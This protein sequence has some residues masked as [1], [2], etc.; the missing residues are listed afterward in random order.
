M[1]LYYERKANSRR[2]K[3][4]IKGAEVLCFSKV[5]S[6]ALTGGEFEV[7]RRLKTFLMS[8]PESK[9]SLSRN[10]AQVQCSSLI[11]SFTQKDGEDGKRGLKADKI[12]SK[13]F[14]ECLFVRVLFNIKP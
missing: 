4:L 12:C 7:R 3:N 5:I 1:L 11:F 6:L 2:N 9:W 10:V 14:Y 13:Y 8:W